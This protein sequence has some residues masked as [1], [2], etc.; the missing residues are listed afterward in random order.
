MHMRRRC[1]AK[2]IST[3]SV[4]YPFRANRQSLSRKPS[5]SAAGRRIEL[6]EARFMLDGLAWTYGPAL[7]AALGNV[8]A[9]N[10]FVG[11][12]VASGATSAAG[13]TTP[14]GAYIFDP[15]DPTATSW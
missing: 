7:P 9:L 15:T 4:R 11:V 3:G 2:R 1:S 14:R 13:T 12:L 6:L 8:A 5:A 10:T